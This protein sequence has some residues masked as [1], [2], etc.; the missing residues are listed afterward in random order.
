MYQATFGT[1]CS[2]NT[3]TSSQSLHGNPFSAL[4]GTGAYS[5]LF[6]GGSGGGGGYLNK[7]HTTTT[8]S[9][10]HASVS[11]PATG[12]PA[13]QANSNRPNTPAPTA[14]AN[15]ATTAAG[16]NAAPGSAVALAESA[17][18]V[19]PNGL[20]TFAIESPSA[21][22]EPATLLLLTAG[23]GGIVIARRRSRKSK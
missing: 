2:A 1:V 9:T 22:P 23:A 14:P 11:A 7:N 16:A 3:L 20:A 15:G 5:A 6:F 21:T 19:G 12:H 10:G 13:P 18:P 8:A 4:K 17:T